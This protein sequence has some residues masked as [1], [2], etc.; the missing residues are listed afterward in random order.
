LLSQRPANA[1]G[2]VTAAI[3][4]I[5]AASSN[6]PGPALKIR[7]NPEK[8]AIVYLQSIVAK[9]LVFFTRIQAGKFRCNR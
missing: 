6:H 9:V 4:M 7:A 8:L 1:A 5:A 3:E 2:L